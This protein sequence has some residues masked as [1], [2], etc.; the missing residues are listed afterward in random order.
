VLGFAI[1][2]VVQAWFQG[3]RRAHSAAPGA[4]GGVCH[5][6]GWPVFLVQLR[7]VAIAKSLFQKGA[8]ATSALAFQ[9]ASTNL[10]WSSAWFIWILMGWQSR[11]RSSSRLI[12]IAIMSVLLRRF[13]SARVESR[14]REH[15]LDA[16]SGHQHHSAGESMSVRDRVTSAR[17]WSD[18]AHNFRN[19]WSML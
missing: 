6:S 14:A 8:S 3:S 7:A 4:A 11:S 2:A 17:A 15:A 12:L 1:S 9:F 10:V 13:V 5:W 18:V 16:D 19:D